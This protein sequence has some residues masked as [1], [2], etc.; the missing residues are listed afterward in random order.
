[1]RNGKVRYVGSS[2]YS[3]WQLMLDFIHW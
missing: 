1:V 3:G 2:N